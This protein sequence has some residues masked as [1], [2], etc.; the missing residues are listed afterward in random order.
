MTELIVNEL[1]CYCKNKYDLA[2]VKQLKMVLTSFYTEEELS[3]SK[4]LLYES[5]SKAISDFPRLVKRNKSDSRCRLLV[6]DIIDYITKIDENN[7][8]D[9]LSVYVAQNISRIPTVAI[10]DIEIFIMAQ[11]HTNN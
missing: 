5:A 1:L 9:K 4:Q 3:D 11:S 6:D 10:E 8:W 2:T 7:W